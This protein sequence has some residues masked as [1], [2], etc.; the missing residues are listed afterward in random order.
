MWYS[1]SQYAAAGTDP[2]WPP[3]LKG[4]KLRATF[5][6]GCLRSLFCEFSTG[7][8]GAYAGSNP[9]LTP[10]GYMMSPHRGSGTRGLRGPDPGADAAGLYDVASSRLRNRGLRGLEP[11]LMRGRSRG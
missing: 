8:P 1:D 3:L 2:P 5:A 7:Q 9:G 10:P 4:G 11:G 6:P